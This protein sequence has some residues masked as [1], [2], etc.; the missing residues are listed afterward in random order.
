MTLVSFLW[1]AHRYKTI[2]KHWFSLGR[3]PWTGLRSIWGKSW[4]DSPRDWV[5]AEEQ[6]EKEGRTWVS[7]LNHRYKVVLLLKMRNVGSPGQ[8][9]DLHSQL[10]EK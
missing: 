4:H 1:E 3:K 2:K 7:D 8:L 9:P 5:W 6:R 10:I